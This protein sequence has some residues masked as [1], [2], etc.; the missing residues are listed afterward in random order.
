M[1]F[2]PL[3]TVHFNLPTNSPYAVPSTLHSTFPLLPPF[4]RLQNSYI[5]LAIIQQFATILN[6]SQMVHSSP[7]I[8]NKKNYS[9][10]SH[11]FTNSLQLPVK[12]QNNIFYQAKLLSHIKIFQRAQSWHMA[13][14][15]YS[16]QKWSSRELPLYNT[17]PSITSPHS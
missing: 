7:I 5:T 2:H 12:M 10:Q 16:R 17:R 11:K 3:Y 8:T 13:H 9:P 6:P 1:Q 15:C 4:H 14:T